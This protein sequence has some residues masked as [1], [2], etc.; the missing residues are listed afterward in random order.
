[1]GSYYVLERSVSAIVWKVFPHALFPTITTLIAFSFHAFL[2]SRLV[3]KD[4]AW[5][6]PERQWRWFLALILTL[7]TPGMSE[8]AGNLTNVNWLLFYWLAFLFLKD[9]SRPLTLGDSIVALLVSL[10]CGFT[11]LLIPLALYRAWLAPRARYNVVPAVILIGMTALLALSKNTSVAYIENPLYQ[12][13]AILI[14]SFVDSVV[15]APWIG[16]WPTIALSNFSRPLNAFIGLAFALTVGCLF[17]PHR[18]KPQVAVIT[19]LA[20]GLFLWPYLCWLA[21][22]GRIQYFELPLRGEFWRTR[23][24]LPMAITAFL[25]WYVIFSFFKNRRVAKAVGTTFFVLNLIW[26][27]YKFRIAEY[28]PESL[29][30][31]S[32]PTIERWTERPCE[33]LKLPIYPQ[34]WNIELHDRCSLSQ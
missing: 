13:I 17:W 9:P 14:E 19:L 24:S 25:A 11:I 30:I 2:A 31:R 21:R 29:W 15:Y 23:Y 28:G 26:G 10:S 33:E 3:K 22:P 16:D 4:Y 5:L 8:M 18:R 6:I 34:G 27:I 12:Q 32:V 7:S 20:A 1:M